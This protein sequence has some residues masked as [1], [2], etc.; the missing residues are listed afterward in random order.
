M[1]MLALF[2]LIGMAALSTGCSYYSAPVMPPGGLFYTDIQA[3]VD[4][5]VQ[6]NPVGAK[7]G[8]ATSTSILGLFSTG[9][10]S[11]AEAVRDGNLTQVDHVD[12]EFFNLLFI[13]QKFTIHAYGE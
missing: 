9:D 10:A 11:L 7:V 6:S 8:S 3:P 5:D 1:R 2:T 12:Y 13:Y 4:T